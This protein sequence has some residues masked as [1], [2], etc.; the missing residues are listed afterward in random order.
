M[1]AYNIPNTTF[2]WCPTTPII[3]TASGSTIERSSCLELFRLTTDST[4]TTQNSIG[5][6]HSP[7]R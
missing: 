4:G 6:V 3:A 5:K 1:E 7:S 2:T